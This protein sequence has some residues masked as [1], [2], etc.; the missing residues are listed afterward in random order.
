MS[1]LLIYDIFRYVADNLVLL[2]KADRKNGNSEELNKMLMTFDEMTMGQIMAGF[3]DLC[4]IPHQLLPVFLVSEIDQ[5]TCVPY[6]D[7]V[8]SSGS[9][10]R[11]LPG[12]VFRVRRSGNRCVPRPIWAAAL[13]HSPC[14]ATCSTMASSYFARRFPNTPVFHLCFPVRYEDESLQSAAEDIKACIKFIED[15]TGAKWNWTLTSPL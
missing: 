15:Q 14:P 2:S 7:A 11:Y 5:L 3:P 8:E 6:I 9:A 4:G 12:S 1:H 10:L 13:S